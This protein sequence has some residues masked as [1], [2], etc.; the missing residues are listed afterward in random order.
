MCSEFEFGSWIPS[1]QTEVSYGSSSPI[2]AQDIKI[3]FAMWSPQAPHSKLIINVSSYAV[4]CRSS[5]ACPTFSYLLRQHIQNY[6]GGNVNIWEVI[7]SDILSK[8][9]IIYIY[10]CRIQNGFRDRA[11]SLYS[12]KIVNKEDI[13]RIVYN[14]GIYCSS[15]KVDTVYLI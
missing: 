10:M 5:S 15:D 14:T 4:V 6:P 11:I 2:Q 8:K 9:K 12:S 13:L 7:L 3:I 1:I